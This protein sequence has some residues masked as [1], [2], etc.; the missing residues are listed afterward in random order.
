V[1]AITA[2]A[3]LG[4][5]W[6]LRIP[7]GRSA[8]FVML[9]LPCL[10]LLA[11]FRVWRRPE[12]LL[13]G[14]GPLG[15]GVLVFAAELPT[16][17]FSRPIVNWGTPASFAYLFPDREPFFGPGGRLRPDLRARLRSA[18][19]PGGT[20]ILTNP[21]GFRTSEPVSRSGEPGEFRILSL[22][23][24]FTCGYGAAQDEFF[25]SLLERGLQNGAGGTRVRVL[26][27]EV[28]DPVLGLYYLQT[29]GAAFH[30]DLVVY[31]LSGNDVIQCAQSCGPGRRFRIGDDAVLAPSPDSDPPGDLV[32]EMKDWSYPEAG[33]PSSLARLRDRVGGD[34]GVESS[35]SPF[36]FRLLA[37]LARARV[38][39]ASVMPTMA[40]RYEAIDGRRRLVDG[41]A[42]LGHYYLRTPDRTEALNA[43]VRPLLKGLK[44]AAAAVDA[45]FLLVVFPQR[46]QVRPEDWQVMRTFWNLK[47]DDFDLDLLNRE[48]HRFCASE[49]IDS[50]DLLDAFRAATADLY[51]PAGDMHWNR[52]GHRLAAERTAAFISER[53]RSR[54]R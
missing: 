54:A 2:A 5:A 4:W 15:V 51:L 3:A 34:L 19:Y 23:D 37:P 29:W 47:A 27:A 41:Y 21:D 40:Q 26:S 30:P 22:G 33:P 24:S 46:Y 14:L 38:R 1:A 6:G 16:L 32:S 50:L 49:G 53:Y 20:P 39:R 52:L 8:V 9:W 48:I 44:R 36:V 11:V 35:P 42:N 31:G 18:D 25:G 10:A 17:D 43:S 28:S 7:E 45:P 13:A 12:L